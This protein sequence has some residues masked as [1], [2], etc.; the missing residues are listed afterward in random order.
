MLVFIF[1]NVIIKIWGDTM[2]TRYLFEQDLFPKLFDKDPVKVINKVLTEKNEYVIGLMKEVYDKK[3]EEMPYSAR[4]LAIEIKSDQQIDFI[5]I[6]MPK[7]GIEI[8]NCHKIILVYSF[9]LD[10][11]KYYTLEEGFNK[12][13]GEF[14]SISAWIENSHIN[15]GD[16]GEDDIIARILATLQV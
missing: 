12:E 13:N 6:D 4:D 11:F 15:F 14:K 9:M 2:N 10:L 5:I 8:G 1:L 3:N 16:L 7:F